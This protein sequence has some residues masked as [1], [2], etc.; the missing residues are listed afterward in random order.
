[1]RERKGY[2]NDNLQPV[3]GEISPALP[4]AKTIVKKLQSFNLDSEG[5]GAGNG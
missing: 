2:S 5:E 3:V 1:M 4:D